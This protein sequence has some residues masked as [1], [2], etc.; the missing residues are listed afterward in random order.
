[1]AL[2]AGGR[3]SSPCRWLRSQPHRAPG[4]PYPD[5]QFDDPLSVRSPAQLT[6]FAST[7]RTYIDMIMGTMTAL[8]TK[9]RGLETTMRGETG[10]LRQQA[11]STIA[12]LQEQAGAVLNRMLQDQTDAGQRLDLV[13]ASA[14]A[15]FAT[16]DG[17]VSQTRCGLEEVAGFAAQLGKQHQQ[18]LQQQQLLEQQLRQ[19][20]LPAG[21]RH[22][23]HGAL[24]RFRQPGRAWRTTIIGSGPVRRHLEAPAHR[25]HGEANAASERGHM[26]RGDDW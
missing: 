5:F 1:M 3:L 23:S 22:C 14:E 12:S 21:S 20:P 10:D 7:T 15:K 25:E 4:A 19:Q 9:I 2:A 16:V 13:V 8:H 18:L 26:Q 6:A 24:P 11:A 17:R